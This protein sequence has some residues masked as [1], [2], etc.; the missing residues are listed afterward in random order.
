MIRSIR[1]LLAVALLA[2][3]A[4]CGKNKTSDAPEQSYTVRAKVE[5]ID[6]REITLRHEAIPDFVNPFGE[7]AVMESMA[8]RFALGDGVAT[9]DV[10]PGDVVEVRFHTDWDERPALRIDSVRELPADTR[11]EL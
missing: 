9:G 3:P 4:G 8:M 7:R 6:G 11:L 10:V 1:L 2:A 5:R